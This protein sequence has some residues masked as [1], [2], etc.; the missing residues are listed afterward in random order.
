MKITLASAISPQAIP[1][2]FF[3]KD[4]ALFNLPANTDSALFKD[5]LTAFK[6]GTYSV[7]E[8]VEL[9]EPCLL[10]DTGSSAGLDALD[11]LR[12]AACRIQRYAAKRRLAEICLCMEGASPVQVA[13]VT[14]GLHLGAYRFDKYKSKPKIP[15][16]VSVQ[17]FTGKKATAAISQALTE[18]EKISRL[19]TLCKDLVNEPGGS[20][21]P[22][23]F[24]ER[25][26]EVARQFGLKIKVRNAAQ[27][28]KEGFE[29]LLAVGRGGEH[30]P[31]MVTLQY[32]P[33]KATKNVHL[34]IAGK[35]VTF[36]TGGLSLKPSTSMWEMRL[37]MAGAAT[38]LAGICAISTLKLPVRTT[39]VL[40][41]T[42]NRP[43]KDA[44]LP[45]DI[46]KARNGKTVMVENTD[47]EGRLIL[48]DAFW[49]LGTFKV[50]HLV[51]IATLT[52]AIVKAL[53]HV[54]AGLFSNN[55]AFA[56]TIRACGAASG[57]KFWSMP[58]EEEY[59]DSLKDTV[60]DMRNVTGEVGAIIAAI[61]LS[62]FVPENTAWAHWDI[63]GTAF[64]TK[65]WKYT[66]H[67][68]TGFGVRTLVELARTLGG[69]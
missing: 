37:D 36:D 21:N 46:F 15:H 4:K 41:L 35:G 32:T 59:R 2:L 20:L 56:Q 6:E 33:P 18:E 67:G 16:A 8:M 53:G 27:L 3:A 12:L 9:P 38:A 29:G 62:E 57:D 60:A 14:A 39:A 64:V 40:C 66:A 47:A 5:A 13:A 44:I 68:A 1:V 17:I 30:P 63:A 52:G 69:S 65:E 45:G 43:G 49:E 55:E 22:Q 34:G 19:I 54:Q 25:I 24:T 11:S 61:F 10:A 58:I 42:E 48:T 50:S 7:L 51:D 23:I 26:E 28:R 31:V